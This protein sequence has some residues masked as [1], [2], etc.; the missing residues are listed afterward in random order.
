MD[1]GTIGGIAG[2]LV[3]L[4][5]TMWTGGDLGSF[6]NLPSF[7]TTVGGTFAALFV[8]Y[9]MSKLMGLGAITRHAIYKREDNPGEMIGMLVTFSEKA[10]R[11]GLLALEDDIDEVDDPFLKKGVQLVV[12]GTDPEL[13]RS[14]MLTD[15]DKIEARHAMGKDIYD[16]AGLLA[17]AFGMIGTLIGLIQML[18]NLTDKASIG[19]GMGIAL[20]TT[21]YGAILSNLIF[22]PIAKKLES[23]NYD[24]ILLKE[25][26]LEGTLS[27][28]SG[29]NPRIVKD[30]LTS[31]LPPSVRADVAT[32]VS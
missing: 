17:P 7:L 1:L 19:I 5:A 23:R 10:R 2:G 18:A 25:I 4:I 27:I 26:M 3:L 8:A 12:D 16:M 9:P 29:D 24:E 14:I 28:Q 31:F 20:I 6:A 22:Q 32:E 13:V 21:L 11:E 15:L 30:K